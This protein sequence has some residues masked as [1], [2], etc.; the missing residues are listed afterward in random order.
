[1]PNH[2][3]HKMIF[4]NEA[5]KA[6]FMELKTV[7][8]DGDIL[9]FHHF[10]PTKEPWEFDDAVAKHGTKWGAYSQRVEE[11]G[12]TVAIFFKTAWSTA[13]PV[14]GKI[15]EDYPDVDIH[16]Y[17]ADEDF[18]NNLG[19]IRIKDGEV[20]LCECSNSSDEEQVALLNIVEGGDVYGFC[21][22][23]GCIEHN[24]YQC[25]CEREEEGGI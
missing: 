18:G 16:I 25:E 14:W 21:D 6:L 15:A 1:M 4:N 12:G 10:I 7:G 11:E 22:G 5:A 17:Y 9:N 23:C 8:K 3:S 19:L 13:E 24:D 20:D 2:V